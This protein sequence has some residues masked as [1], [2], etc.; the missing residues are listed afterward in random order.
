MTEMVV[1]TALGTL[2]LILL[3]TTWATFGATAL[4]VEARSR[5]QREAILAVQSLAY[6]LGGFLND[7]P[8]ATTPGRP[9]GSMSDVAL[10]NPYQFLD[11]DTSNSG[12]LLLNYSGGS[13]SP[14]YTVR[15]QLE[16]DPNSS[17]GYHLVRICTNLSTA[18]SS[19]V[20]VARHVAQNGL[21]VAASGPNQVQ[22]QLTIVYRNI[23][24]TFTL[25]GVPPAS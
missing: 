1:A 17:E 24:S 22:I 13:S 9:G 10:K 7:D 12:I 6:D 3:T 15:Y 18:I 25:I 16:S 8:S 23:S 21:S 11:W 14:A 19:K 4:E 5:V 20:T 2:V